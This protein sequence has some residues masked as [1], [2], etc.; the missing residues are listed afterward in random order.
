MNYMILYYMISV[1]CLFIARTC[2]KR[3]WYLM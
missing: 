2:A 1:V 3:Y